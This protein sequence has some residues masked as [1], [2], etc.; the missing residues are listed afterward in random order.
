MVT[1]E[2]A[3][4]PRIPPSTDSVQRVGVSTIAARR[5]PISLRQIWLAG[6]LVL[7]LGALATAILLAPPESASPS[8]ALQWLLFVGS[9]GHVAATAW[10]YSVP[11]VRAYALARRARYVHVPIALVVCVGVVA[12]VLGPRKL[13]WLLL[14]FFGWQ[15]F[16]FQ[17]QNLGLAAL[18]GVSQ[19]AG[20]LR[21][22]ERSA[23]VV[24]GVGG[25]GGLLVHP[26]LLEL[27]IDAH[28]RFL[29][30][31]AAAVAAVGVLLGLHALRAR[32]A[33]ERPRAFVA[34]YLVSLLFFLPVFVFDS[35]Y[36]AVAG[37]TLAHGLQ[38][39][40]LVG[41]IAAARRQ[42]Q[43]P[44][45]SLAVLF[46]AALL[47]GLLLNATSHLHAAN[48]PMRALY[49]A[50]L[51]IVMAHFVVDA[52]LWRLRDDFPRQFLGATVPYLVQPPPHL[53]AASALGAK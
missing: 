22:R 40:L 45:V 17:K 44:L 30:P 9:S 41:L 27:A 2:G 18:A 46:N 23:L 47:G 13:E 12:M 19:G 51:G 6:T 42:D 36:A 32:A 20:S 34:V 8:R 25:I 50:Y 33:A 37:L 5:T 28:V 7:T 53:P 31:I 11:E 15:F 39:L 1:S 14:G 3:I 16:H 48:A 10:F 43:P 24:A 4:A 38:Y 26:E 52:G 29:F 35:P 21:P 49:G